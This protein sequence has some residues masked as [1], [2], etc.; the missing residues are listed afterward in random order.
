ML[1][2]LTIIA[3]GV[4]VA[5]VV[6]A[7][8]TIAIGDN[9]AQL[10]ERLA[11]L[12]STNRRGAAGPVQSS[13]LEKSLAG[14]SRNWL[15]Q[16]LGELPGLRA[17]NEQAASPL[18]ITQLIALTFGL[19]AAGVGLTLLSP[20]PWF[21][22]PL[23]GLL[24][25]CLPPLWLHMRRKRR[26]A[27]FGRQLPEALE[28]LSRSLKAGH[29]LAAGFGLIGSEMQEPIKSEFL[30]TFEEQ[31][32]GVT[33]EQALE[34]MTERVPNMDLR[35]FA[36]AVILQRT[37]GG[38]LAEIL[39]KIGRLVRERIQIHGQIQAL[40]GEGRLS[41][42]VLLALPPVLFLVMLYLNHDYAM[43]LFTDPL[44]RKMLAGALVMQFL[45]ALMIRK[46]IQIKV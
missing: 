7:V 12:T 45:G 36:T 39:N 41:G 28:L 31:N 3:T 17:Y 46:I 32:L 1:T 16:L 18:S 21:L 43:M 38:D 44:G 6:A 30:R 5:A 10:E 22:A 4:A 29:S 13:L 33:L 20:L 37:T 26:L 23:S 34:G 24:L 27:A 2:T 25:G 8:A 35:F 42:I 9:S 15:E 40:T 14:E 19:V 11:S